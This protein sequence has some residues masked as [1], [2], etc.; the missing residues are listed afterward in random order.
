MNLFSPSFRLIFLFSV[1]VLF[2]GLSLKP[3][4]VTQVD[5]IIYLNEEKGREKQGVKEDEGGQTERGH[6]YICRLC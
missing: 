4:K 5:K 6:F 1:F 3:Y 2:N